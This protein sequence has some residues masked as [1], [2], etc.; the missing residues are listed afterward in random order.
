MIEDYCTLVNFTIIPP[1]GW[2]TRPGFGRKSAVFCVDSMVKFRRS[3]ASMTLSSII[4]N[5][6]PETR[7]KWEYLS[8]SVKS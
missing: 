8:V 4:A 1:D 3:V 5:F 6:C 2:R 7:K